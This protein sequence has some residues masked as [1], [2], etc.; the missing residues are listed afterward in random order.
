MIYHPKL[1]ND[2]N[3]V[4]INNPSMPTDI[5]T[6]LAPSKAATVTPNGDLPGELNGISFDDWTDHP[7]CNAE[8]ENLAA[9]SL[10]DE[11][12]FLPPKNKKSAA[13]VVI[14]ES[15][16]R[17]WLVAPSNAYGGYTATFPKGTVEHGASL[18]A[19]ALK[20]AFEET[21]LRVEIIGFLAD[22][23]RS[24]TFTRYYRARRLGGS[25]A[26]MGWESQAVHLV[27][28]ES[29]TKHVTHPNDKQ[30]L[31]ILL[32]Y[33]VELKAH[34]ILR[35]QYGLTSGHRVLAAISGYR[36]QTG[37]WPTRI[38]MDEHSIGGIRNGVFTP[39]GWKLLN[40]KVQIT[41][42]DVLTIY[43]E[44]QEGRVEYGDHTHLT[45][46]GDE[47]PDVWIWGIKLTD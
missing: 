26:C 36:H 6:W 25:P 20:E 40:Q 4:S 28:R 17:I 41:S 29:L 37:K 35:N 27:S 39:L 34:D 7:Q 32:R 2:G 3:K 42:C 14:E 23:N 24:T 5:E 21:G 13:G 38:L 19:T 43:A 31:E 11:P 45:D 16:G 46:E 47:R 15:D 22:S 9:K 33:P 18:H 44:G 8:W 10:V 1:D 30:L 12:P